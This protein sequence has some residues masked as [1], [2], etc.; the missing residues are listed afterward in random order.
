MLDSY[1]A[2]P[3]KHFRPFGLGSRVW[4]N[5]SAFVLEKRAWLA[6][7]SESHALQLEWMLLNHAARSI[8]RTFI[9]E[10]AL[11]QKT[12]A[13]VYRKIAKHKKETQAATRNLWKKATALLEVEKKATKKKK[14]DII[15]GR[16]SHRPAHLRRIQHPAR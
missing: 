1:M 11:D 8:V 6:G 7:R 3:S 2:I 16:K 10:T 4:N 13:Q 14:V 5:T 12:I 15:R 9:R